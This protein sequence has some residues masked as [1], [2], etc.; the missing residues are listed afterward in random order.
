MLLFVTVIGTLIAVALVYSILTTRGNSLSQFTLF[1]A[2]G[3]FIAGVINP[4]GMLYIFALSTAY[5][6]LLKRLLILFDR[7]T[8]LDLYFVMGLAP[9]IMLGILCG[10]VL[11]GITGRYQL[12]KRH[13]NLFLIATGVVAITALFAFRHHG[14]TIAIK[15]ISNGAAYSYLLFVLPV[16]FRSWTDLWK[17]CRFILFIFIPVGLYAIYQSIFGLS[18]FEV[19]YLESGLTIMIKELRDVRPRPFSTMNAAHTLAYMSSVLMVLAYIPFAAGKEYRNLVRHRGFYGCLIFFYFIVCFVTM[20]RSGH[21]LWMVAFGGIFAFFTLRRTALF[22]GTAVAG[23]ALMVVFAERLIEKLPVWDAMLNKSN[24]FMMQATRIQTFY[25]RLYS[26]SQLKRAETYSL[27]GLEHE[28]FTHDAVTETI[29]KYGLVPLLIGLV[30]GISRIT[31]IHKAVCEVVSIG[32]RKITGLFLAIG[33]GILTCD[34]FFGSTSKVFPLSAYLWAAFGGALIVVFY[35]K[36]ELPGSEAPVAAA[37]V[38]TQP[39][40]SRPPQLVPTPAH[41]QPNPAPIHDYPR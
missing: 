40:H 31:K 12:E 20:A 17:L 8:V 18:Q 30:I 5:L 27:F 33:F 13:W 15:N 22:Y 4:K 29:A 2:I 7:P 3:C 6:D 23:Y 19:E 34:V 26:Y 11:G 28:I 38:K 16:L 9:L 39:T 25:D 41:F 21:F 14:A 24:S 10:V 36:N 37:P 35:Q 1:A 32:N